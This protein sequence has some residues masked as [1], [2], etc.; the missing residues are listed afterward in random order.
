MVEKPGCKKRPKPLTYKHSH[1][2]DKAEEWRR[3]RRQ[4][5]QIKNNANGK[6]STKC[7]Q[8]RAGGNGLITHLGSLAAP[9]PVF[10]PSRRLRGL[11]RLR[12]PSSLTRWFGGW[13]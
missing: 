11:P 5:H 13:I 7:E 1:Q 10:L 2:S 4:F 3:R 9:I 8:H 12:R 6:T